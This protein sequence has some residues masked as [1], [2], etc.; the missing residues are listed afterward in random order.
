MHTICDIFCAQCPGEPPVG[1]KYV[2]SLSTQMAADDQDQ[3]YKEGKYIL[4]EALIS[5]KDWI[6][7]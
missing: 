7:D 2:S 4:E 3:K 6:D 1:W 5:H